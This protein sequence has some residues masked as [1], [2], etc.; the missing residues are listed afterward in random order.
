MAEHY[1]GVRRSKL[2]S[3]I[4][5]ENASDAEQMRPSRAANDNTFPGVMQIRATRGETTRTPSSASR[6]TPLAAASESDGPVKK[7]PALEGI[8]RMVNWSQ[9]AAN[10]SHAVRL[11]RATHVLDRL[12]NIFALFYTEEAHFGCKMP[13]LVKLGH[14]KI[15][16]AT[17]ERIFGRSRKTSFLPSDGS[18][19]AKKFCQVRGRGIVLRT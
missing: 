2:A 10:W 3:I 17:P 19:P 6:R 1:F 4:V 14:K 5:L 18:Q 13:F 8:G 11:K 16:Q 15:L 9:M 7:R 12:P